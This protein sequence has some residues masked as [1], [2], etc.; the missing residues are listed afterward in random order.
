MSTMPTLKAHLGRKCDKS[1]EHTQ[2]SGADT[3]LTGR[4]PQGM[5]DSVHIAF[6]EACSLRKVSRSNVDVGSNIGDATDS[7]GF[8]RDPGTQA[9]G[10]PSPCAPVRAAVCCAPPV[11]VK[12]NRSL[13][14]DV[15]PL[16]SP[17]HSP[18]A[19]A[20]ADASATTGSSL[21]KCTSCTRGASLSGCRPTP[22]VSGSVPD[23]GGF[24]TVEA[25]AEHRARR[26]LGGGCP[27]P[28]YRLPV[29]AKPG[30][31]W[32]P[33]SRWCATRCASS[34]G[35]LSAPPAAGGVEGHVYKTYKIVGY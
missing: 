28:R 3:V 2:V 19:G 4:Y 10:I 24:T 21:V 5:A 25:D 31:T 12:T 33:S 14:P 35:S 6:A 13:K 30:T 1:H 32:C 15:Y 23:P 8:L 9:R 11:I 22:G 17:L 16:P 18:G 27:A 29:G 26:P 20:M 7:G 34:V